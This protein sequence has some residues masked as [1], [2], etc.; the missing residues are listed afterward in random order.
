MART[1]HER[2]DKY[3]DDI[4]NIGEAI[5]YLQNVDGMEEIIDAL[6][7]KLIDLRCEYDDVSRDIERDDEMDEQD[8]RRE[9][10]EDLL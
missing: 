1:K 3:A 7:D 8:L 4:Y 5:D 2:M 9:Y 10:E 6:N